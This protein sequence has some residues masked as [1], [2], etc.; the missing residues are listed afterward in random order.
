METMLIIIAFINGVLVGFALGHSIGKSK[1]P[2]PHPRS[3][4]NGKN[5]L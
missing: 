5:N 1:M 3:N 2:T 4:R